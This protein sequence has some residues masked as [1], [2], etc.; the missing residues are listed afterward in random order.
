MRLNKEQ[1]KAIKEASEAC[2]PGSEVFLF[3]SRIDENKRGGDIDLLINTKTKPD[4]KIKH[5]IRHKIWEKL[6]E[7]KIDIVFDYPNNDS[8][9]IELIKLETQKL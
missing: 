5:K 1:I 6:G 4:R 8:S 7:Q 3:G 2:L 9:F